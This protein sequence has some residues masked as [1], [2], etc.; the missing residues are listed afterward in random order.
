MAL[1]EA[2]ARRELPA[3]THLLWLNDDVVLDQGAVDRLLETSHDHPDAIIAGALRDPRTDE[4]TYSGLSRSGWHPLRYQRVAPDAHDAKT[5][6]TFN[7]NL[8]LVPVAK[9]EELG[10]IDGAFIHQFADLDYGHR[11]TEAGIEVLLAAGIFG[12]CPRNPASKPSGGIAERWRQFH[13]HHYFP[14]T[15][16]KRFLKRHGGSAWWL[17]LITP[18]PRLLIGRSKRGTSPAKHESPSSQ[19]ER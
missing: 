6:E 9:A 15:P 3:T 14:F 18:Y 12:S 16:R 19:A 11:A 17:F 13:S 1:G 10:S 8:V 7:G 4:I 5:V 2:T